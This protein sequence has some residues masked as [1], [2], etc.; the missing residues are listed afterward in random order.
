MPNTDMDSK[1]K[2]RKLSTGDAVKNGKKMKK[3]SRSAEKERDV[4]TVPT[5]DLERKG[6][7]R[8]V[9]PQRRRELEEVF[10]HHRKA[11]DFKWKL[12]MM[13]IF[14]CIRDAKI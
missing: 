1:G 9:D 11:D 2:K 6:N 4:C 5:G 13:S 14:S 3:L 10:K 8:K 7:Q 12:L